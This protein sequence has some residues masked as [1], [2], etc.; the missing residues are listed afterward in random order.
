MVFRPVRRRRRFAVVALALAVLAALLST[1]SAQAEVEHPRQQWMRDSTAG[2]FL[3]WGMFTAPRHTDCA[4]WER[5]VTDGGWKN[6]SH[7]AYSS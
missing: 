4:T 3:H 7:A 5:D 6:P 2:L 1:T